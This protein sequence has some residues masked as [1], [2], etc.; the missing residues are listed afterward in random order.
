MAINR[1]WPLRR[2]FVN[3]AVAATAF[4]DIELEAS[5]KLLGAQASGAR[6]S[7]CSRD[8]RI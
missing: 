3:L 5:C 1:E 8:P 7:K 6:P 4:R 2:C